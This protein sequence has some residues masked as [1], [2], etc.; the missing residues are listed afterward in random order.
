MRQTETK[1]DTKQDM[2]RQCKTCVF[3]LLGYAGRRKEDL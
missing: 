2:N 3:R 1:C